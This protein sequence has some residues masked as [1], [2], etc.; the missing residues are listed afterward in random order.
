MTNSVDI[1][2]LFLKLYN[3]IW[4]LILSTNAILIARLDSNIQSI[5]I[6]MAILI[7]WEDWISTVKPKIQQSLI[8]N[9][10]AA[11]QFCW[12]K[13]LTH[14]IVIGLQL[15]ITELTVVL[16]IY[17][18]KL[19]VIINKIQFFLPNRGTCHNPMHLL[20]SIAAVK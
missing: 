15:C 7:P 19:L 4:R 14:S 6:T 3:P 13:L 5:R 11:L 8:K 16:F 20:P 1:V 18:L 9:I 10:S 2:P 17:R 12:N